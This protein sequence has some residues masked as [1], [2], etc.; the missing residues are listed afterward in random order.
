GRLD[1]QTHLHLSQ[2]SFRQ[3]SPTWTCHCLLRGSYPPNGSYN[4]IASIRLCI[5]VQVLHTLASCRIP[6]RIPSISTPAWR[7]ITASITRSEEPQKRTQT[8]IAAMVPAKTALS[9]Q[10]LP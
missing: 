1:Y 10:S 2:T 3:Q 9:L 4:R 5:N 8:S 7:A 6:L